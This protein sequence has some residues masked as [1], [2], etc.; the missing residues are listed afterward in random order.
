MATDETPDI[1]DCQFY[2]PLAKAVI[3]FQV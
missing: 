3:P 2:Q 1:K